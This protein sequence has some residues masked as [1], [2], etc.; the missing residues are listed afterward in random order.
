MNQF[1]LS[2]KV[3][4]KGHTLDSKLQRTN[5][6]AL[7]FGFVKVLVALTASYLVSQGHHL[8]EWVS[9]LSS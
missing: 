2:L 3:D 4:W 5:V 7:A 1:S 6:V 8:P 9:I